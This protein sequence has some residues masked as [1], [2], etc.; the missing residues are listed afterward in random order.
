[1]WFAYIERLEYVQNMNISVVNRVSVGQFML[2]MHGA[3]EGQLYL[4]G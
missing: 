4:N 3:G 2:W 1:M